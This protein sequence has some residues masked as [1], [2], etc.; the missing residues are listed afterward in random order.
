MQFELQEPNLWNTL[1]HFREQAKTRELQMCFGKSIP[2]SV[3]L[4]SKITAF[5]CLNLRFSYF[6]QA[7]IKRKT[8]QAP[9]HQR[10][11]PARRHCPAIPSYA[12]LTCQAAT[13]SKAKVSIR[14]FPPARPPVYLRSSLFWSFANYARPARHKMIKLNNCDQTLFRPQFCFSRQMELISMID[15]AKACG[16]KSSSTPTDCFHAF[17]F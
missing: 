1:P 5:A 11:P 14:L 13:P 17:P 10:K 6:V 7:A 4:C 9:L 16:V 8:Q 3:P 15:A 2:C 12:D